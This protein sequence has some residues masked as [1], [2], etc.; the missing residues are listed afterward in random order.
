MPKISVLMPVY[1][2]ANIVSETIESILNQTF[3]DFELICIDDGSKDNT[4]EVVKN[5]AANDK[6]I[7][8]LSKENG[9]TAALS[10][11]FSI[12]FIRSDFYFF[13]S[14]DDLFS[15]D[16]L[17]KMYQKALETGA[18]CILPDIVIYFGE[19]NVRNYVIGMSDKSKVLT[20]K[21]A[22]ALSLDWT[23]GGNGLHRTSI[24]QKYG[25]DYFG[26]S[27]DEYLVRISF[28]NAKEVVFSEG[29]FYYRQV[30]SAVTKKVSPVLFEHLRTE[31]KLLKLVQN[32]N[33]E[34]K[35]IEQQ[36]R[37][38]LLSILRFSIIY[39]RNK[40]F[41]NNLQRKTIKT[42]IFDVCK[43]VN[44]DSSVMQIKFNIL[45]S[46]CILKL[47]K[48]VVTKISWEFLYFAIINVESLVYNLLRKLTIRVGMFPKSS[49]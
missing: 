18:D 23:I 32:N 45:R 14:H 30:D 9:G 19:N 35:I 6:R 4:L 36:Y 5:Y 11:I 43:E 38:L 24:L 17:E 22:V 41:L 49:N 25:H 39:V 12:P 26:F 31:Y 27:S 8:V 3:K 46:N 1:N 13:T 7:V 16:L 21:E 2:A 34:Q 33:F 15:I 47:N 29:Q 37:S 40:K 48:F 42:T 20:G 28:L 44:N 10:I